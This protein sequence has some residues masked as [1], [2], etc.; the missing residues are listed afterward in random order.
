MTL[1]RVKDELRV[2]GTAV[3]VSSRRGKSVFPAELRH[4]GVKCPLCTVA[5]VENTLLFGCGAC[6]ALLHCE[7]ERW[8]EQERLECARLASTCPNCHQAIDFTC[9][10]EWEPEL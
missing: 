1:L 6:G 10:M 7:D 3:F 8:P 4:V 9:G 5:I 2:D